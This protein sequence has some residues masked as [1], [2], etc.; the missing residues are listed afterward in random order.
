M[1]QGFLLTLLSSVTV[2][3][4]MT[5]LLLWMLKSLISTRLKSAVKFEYDQRLKEIDTQLG[6]LREDRT[7]KLEKLLGHYERQIEEFYGPLWNMVHQLYVCNETKDRLTEKLNRDE[8][9]KV[10][11]Y[12]QTNYF[13][14][15]HDEIR[16]IIKTKLYLIDGERMPE[17]FY[18][19]LRHAL[20]E[21][22]QQD[23]AE[24]FQVD[25]SFLAGVPW[26]GGFD[27]EIRDG[28][29][30]SMEKYEECLGGLR[31]EAKNSKA[32]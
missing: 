9:K 17:S 27:D 10:N 13:R 7:R 16:Q 20:Q 12:Y 29:N 8:A 15:L 24:Q 3:A 6:V 32:I 19:Y 21:R 4:A 1:E 14:P 2:S 30:R 22:A 25:T 5:G 28:F 26:P 23:L 11:R 18:K 31:A